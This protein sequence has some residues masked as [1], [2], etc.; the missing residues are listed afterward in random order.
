MFPWDTL[1]DVDRAGP[2]APRRHRRPVG[3]HPGRSGRAA[4]PRGAGR[5]QFGARLPD[6]R[7]HAGAAG[8]G[9]RRACSRRYGITGLADDAV[10]PVIGTKELIAWLPTLLGLGADDLVVVP[11][12]AYPDLRSRRSTGRRAGGARGLADPA[13][14]AVA[15]AGL[16][17]LAE[18]PDRQGARRRA[19]PQGGRLGPRARRAGR[20]R[21]VLPG[22]GLGRASRSR[23]CTRRSATATTPGCW[24][25]IRCRRPRRWPATA[26]ASSPATLRWSPN[27]WRCASTPGMMVP[28]PVQAA[29]VAALD[30]DAHEREQRERYARRRAVLLPALRSAG[31]TVD[32]SEAGLYSVGHPRRA[33]P[34][35]RRVAGAAR[36][37]GG[38]RRVLRSA[39]G[40]ARPGGVDRD[41]RADIGCGATA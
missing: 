17:Q 41:R 9:R 33:V 13:R 34:R 36:N 14:P 22:A 32:H 16:S 12:L 35:H 19:S 37:P 25:C 39:R 23:C 24:P 40:T 38:A 21:R 26:R 7:G 8:V 4:D 18:Q 6:H 2:V 15:R 28:T 20:V 3:R 1:A 5:R 27:C 30:D 31:L 11:E 10:L 29:M